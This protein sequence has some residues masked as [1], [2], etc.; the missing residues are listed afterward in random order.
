MTEFAGKT[1]LIIGASSGIGRA[2]VGLF[3]SRGATVIAAARRADKT[4]AAVA[5]ACAAGGTATYVPCDISDEGSIEALFDRIGRDHGRLDCAF[6]NAGVEAPH[7][8]LPDTPLDT[9]DAVFRTNVRGTWL[10]MR[11]EMRMMRAQGYGAIVNTSSIAGLVG[12]PGASAYVASKHAIVG[13]T[14]SASLDLAAQGIRVNC[15]C[16]GATRSEM[17]L[18]WAERLPDG[19][20]GLAAH[21]PMQRIGEAIEP[22]EAAAFLLSDRSAFINGVALVVDGGS[23]VT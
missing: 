4:E 12:F 6:N 8:L 5:E 10:C 1:V 3:A 20:A 11:H 23:T 17:S 2:A 15:I 19:E 18:R 16:P 7:A 21:N 22:A 14:K 13:M 9:F